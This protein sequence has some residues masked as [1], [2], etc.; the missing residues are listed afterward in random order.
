MSAIKAVLETAMDHAF[1]IGRKFDGSVKM[2]DVIVVKQA[3]NLAG[4][5]EEE[6]PEWIVEMI[7]EAY[8]DGIRQTERYGPLQ[9]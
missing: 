2:T 1:S 6:T 9:A 3:I 5:K 8:S 4:L 7:I